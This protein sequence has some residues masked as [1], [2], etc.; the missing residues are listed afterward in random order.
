MGKSKD[1]HESFLCLD[2]TQK[3]I[4]LGGNQGSTLLLDNRMLP[5]FKKEKGEWAS[6]SR[7][8]VRTFAKADQAVNSIAF[9]QHQE[10]SHTSMPLHHANKEILATASN[11]GY[12]RIYD[13]R[14]EEKRLPSSQIYLKSKLSKVIIPTNIYRGR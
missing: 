5:S 2:L 14:N 13:I 7:C 10:L 9:P 3:Y 8:V 6:D 4:A 12:V 1:K 11:D